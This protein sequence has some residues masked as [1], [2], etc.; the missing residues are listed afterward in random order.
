MIATFF[1]RHNFSSGRS[2]LLLVLAAVKPSYASGC[3][4]FRKNQTIWGGGGVAAG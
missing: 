1:K 3:S 2:L 4:E